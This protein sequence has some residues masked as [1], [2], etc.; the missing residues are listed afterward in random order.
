MHTHKIKHPCL[1]KFNEVSACPYSSN[2]IIEYDLWKIIPLENDKNYV[3]HPLTQ[4]FL[5]VEGGKVVCGVPK[6]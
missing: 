4:S 6:F 3:Y 5:G 1:K 2:H